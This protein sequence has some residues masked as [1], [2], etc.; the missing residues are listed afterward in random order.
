VLPLPGS[1]PGGCQQALVS[2]VALIFFATLPPAHHH[3][4]LEV[5]GQRRVDDFIEVLDPAHAIG[6]LGNP[7]PAGDQATCQRS[8]SDGFCGRPVRDQAPSSVSAC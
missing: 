5:C 7:E 6:A 4:L 3:Q 1:C 8:A 2:A